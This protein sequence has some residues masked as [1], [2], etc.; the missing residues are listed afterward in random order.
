[1]RIPGVYLPLLLSFCRS[2]LSSESRA[3]ALAFAFHRLRSGPFE[4]P[5]TVKP[6]ALPEDTYLAWR[7]FVPKEKSDAAASPGRHSTYRFTV[8]PTTPSLEQPRTRRLFRLRLGLGY[9][10]AWRGGAAVTKLVHDLPRRFANF[11]RVEHLV[12]KLKH[13]A[14]RV[15]S[16]NPRKSRGNVA[17][18]I[19]CASSNEKGDT[20]HRADCGDTSLPQEDG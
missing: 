13:L 2:P 8:S 14:L 1:M 12:P 7:T 19:A 9:S 20:E 17:I 11:I 3:I 4:G 6:P 16:G 15:L 18:G 5:A 10:E